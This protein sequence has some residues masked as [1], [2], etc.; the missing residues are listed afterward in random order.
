MPRITSDGHPGMFYLIYRG[1]DLNG[2]QDIM[3]FMK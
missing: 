3:P 1:W 2:F